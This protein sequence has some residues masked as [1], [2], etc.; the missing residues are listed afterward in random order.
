LDFNPVLGSKPVRS[1][2]ER[3]GLLSVGFVGRIQ[4]AIRFRRTEFAEWNVPALRDAFRAGRNHSDIAG[5]GRNNQPAKRPE[6]SFQDGASWVRGALVPAIEQANAELKPEGIAFRLDLNL[7]PRST[8]HAHADFWLTELGEGQRTQG[9][10]FSINV[11]GG[12]TV[13]LYKPGAP[14]GILGTLEQ[15]GPDA[16][17]ELLRAAAEIGEQVGRTARG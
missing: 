7:D 1:A 13:W 2:L 15:C 6:A 17:A 5:A 16:I 9:P 12:Q 14:G 3:L 8:N 4:I 11:I 10:R